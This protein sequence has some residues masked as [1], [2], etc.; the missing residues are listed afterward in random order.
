VRQTESTHDLVQVLDVFDAPTRTALG[1]ALRQL[2]GGLAGYGPGL[3]DFVRSA[4]HVLNSVSTISATLVSGRTDVPGLIHTADRLAGRFAGREEQISELLRQTD[5]TLRALG[6][7]DGKPLAEAIAKLP[8]SLRAVRAALDDAEQP[9]TALASATR[10]LRSGAH[11]LGD[12][13]P[14][15]RGILRE[16]PAPLSTVANVAHAATPAID[17]LSHTFSDARPLAQKLTD[18]LASAAPP[19]KVLAPYAPDIGSLFT[20]TGSVLALHDGWEHRIRIMIG[21]PNPTLL[22]GGQIKDSNSPYPA[23]GQVLHDRDADG[24]LIPGDPGR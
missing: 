4:P 2:G 10:D 21:S 20:D 14:D 13:T 9:L 12:A 8:G 7:D 3:H 6:V 22:L 11:A 15:V 5:E 19:L 1:N 18:G 24:G 16:A 23:P 17:D